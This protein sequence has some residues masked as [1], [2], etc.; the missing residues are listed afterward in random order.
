M[1]AK[2]VKGS[3][4]RFRPDAHNSLL[5][6]GCLLHEWLVDTYARVE[7]QRFTWHRENQD[8]LCADLYQNVHHAAHNRGTAAREIR[9]RIII[10][11]TFLG[12]PR[13]M[14]REYQDA[15]AIVSGKH[16]VFK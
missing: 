9:T 13:Y 8:K 1:Q 5:Q 11:S 15:K 2:G 6:S 10:P 16:P 14:I 4:Q 7:S 12:G 3:R